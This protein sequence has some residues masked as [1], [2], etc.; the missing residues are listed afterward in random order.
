MSEPLPTDPAAVAALG[1]PEIITKLADAIQERGRKASSGEPLYF[2]R[3]NLERVIQETL[4]PEPPALGTLSA[5]AETWDG[6][7]LRAAGDREDPK[8]RTADGYDSG[9]GAI[10]RCAGELRAA[11]AQMRGEK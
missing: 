4:E 1:R 7:A 10:A 2:D 3:H 9:A 5:L 11:L 6:R 8:S